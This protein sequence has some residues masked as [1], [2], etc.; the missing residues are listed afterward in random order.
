MRPFSNK[1]LT[2]FKIQKQ[3]KSA[4]DVKGVYLSQRNASKI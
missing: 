1:T 2:A 4:C 3:H